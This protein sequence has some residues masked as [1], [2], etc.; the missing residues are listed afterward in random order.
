MYCPD[1]Q[2]KRSRSPRKTIGIDEIYGS[3]RVLGKGKDAGYLRYYL[4]CLKC[5]SEYWM[6]GQDIFRYSDTICCPVCRK[7][8]VHNQKMRALQ[9]EYKDRKYGQLKI[10]QITGPKLFP[11]F[12]HPVL[13]A[14]CLCDCG[15]ETEIPL[16]RLKSGGATSC[17]HDREAI[18]KSG[19]DIGRAL[20]VAGTKI[21]SIN[22]QRQ[23][24]QNNTSG[25]NGVSKMKDGKYRAYISF[26]RKRYHL[27]VYES[28][29]LAGEARAT[30]EKELYGNF[31]EWYS[32]T[33]PDEWAKIKEKSE[34]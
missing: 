15:N 12:H 34:K 25:I 7:A 30:A 21:S 4:K 10:V 16:S 14:V 2:K 8:E 5:E 27:G 32:K 3:S 13:G 29:E 23:R 9:A 26:K 24:N 6:T 17:G 20:N 22:G 33:Y 19:Q 1:C 18:L 31:L 28:K 11:G